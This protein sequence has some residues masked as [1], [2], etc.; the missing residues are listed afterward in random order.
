[1]LRVE[2][3]AQ[4]RVWVSSFVTKPCAE[5]CENACINTFIFRRTYRQRHAFYAILNLVWECPTKKWH[6]APQP[7]TPTDF[8]SL[9]HMFFIPAHLPSAWNVWSV[10]LCWRNRRWRASAGHRF[11]GGYKLANVSR[12]SF[13]RFLCGFHHPVQNLSGQNQTALLFKFPR[14][15]AMLYLLWAGPPQNRHFCFPTWLLQ[16]SDVWPH[17]VYSSPSAVCAKSLVEISSA[18]LEKLQ[19]LKCF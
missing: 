18:L 9:N 10:Q 14:L 13:G 15:A 11:E 6:F 5:F 7:D 12:A 16:I 19:Y 4:L 8:R 1:M 17:V 3:R 2:C